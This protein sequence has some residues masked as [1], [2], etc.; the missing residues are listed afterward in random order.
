MP[1]TQTKCIACGTILPVPILSN[2]GQLCATCKSQGL[3]RKEIIITGITRMNSG[4]VCVSGIDPKTWNFIR[5]VFP[6]GLDRDFLMQGATQ[7]VNHL[8][9]F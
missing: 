8:A 5:P 4:N 6:A 1:T 7:V 3:F 9:L 2:V